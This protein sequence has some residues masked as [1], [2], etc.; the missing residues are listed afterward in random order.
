M[1][2]DSNQV[3]ATPPPKSEANCRALRVLS[4]DVSVINFYEAG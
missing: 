2:S 3:A 4:L 1:K